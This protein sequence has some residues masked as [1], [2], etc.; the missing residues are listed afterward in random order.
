MDSVGAATAIVTV[1]GEEVPALLL[2]VYVNES[3]PAY[4]S[5]GV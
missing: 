5:V 4:P 3:P 1:A 2:A